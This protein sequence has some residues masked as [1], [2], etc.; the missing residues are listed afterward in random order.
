MSKVYNITSSNFLMGY[1][2][3]TICSAMSRTQNWISRDL[4][5]DVR[6]TKSNSSINFDCRAR[7]LKAV[8]TG[9]SE[10][11]TL[12][13]LSYNNIQTISNESFYKLQ[14]VSTL[15]I[16]WNIYEREKLKNPDKC[17]KGLDV[18]DGTFLSLSN[19][20][21]LQLNADNI[22][23]IPC[24]LPSSLTILSMKS[25]LIDAVTIHN[26]ADLNNL[27]ELF[28]DKN[29]Y[30]D[31][32]CGHA[33]N[34]QNGTFSNLINLVVF[35]FSYNNLTQVPQHL[36]VSLQKLYLNNNRIQNVS[37]YDFQSLV[38][39]T[40]LD[41]S[42][43]CPRCFNAPNPC[44]PCSGDFS[45]NIHPHAFK[46]IKSLQELYLGGN[47]LY[48]IKSSWFSNAENLKVLD[49]KLNHLTHEIETGDFP[50][51]LPGLERLELSFNYEREKYP[52]YMSLSQNFSNLTSLR[53]LIMRGYVFQNVDTSLNPLFLLKNL[54]VLNLEINFIKQVDWHIFDNM[55]SLTIIDL[56]QNNIVPI[57]KGNNTSYN[58]ANTINSQKTGISQDFLFD[59][60]YINEV[61][62]HS[63][64]R[65]IFK[66]KCN[67]YGKVL[68]LSQ[69][70]IFFIAQEQFKHFNDVACL[71]LSGNALRVPLNGTEFIY[72]TNVQYLDMS[73]NEVDL[74]YDYAFVELKKLEILDLSYNAYYFLIIGITHTLAFIEHLPKLKILNLNG[75][76]IATLTNTNLSS[77]SLKV[78]MF[79]KNRLDVLWKESDERHKNLFSNLINLTDLNISRNRLKFISPSIFQN[80]P[81]S[82]KILNLRNNQLHSFDFG[83]L[84]YFPRLRLLDLSS[85]ILRDVTLNLQNSSLHTLLLARNKIHTL[86]DEFLAFAKSLRYLDLSYNKLG[87]INQ[88]TF[89][90]ENYL[91]VL[92]LKGNPF[93]CTCEIGSFIR[94][95]YSNDV[96]IPR[97]ATDVNC[98]SPPNQ[99]G[100]SIINIDLHACEMDAL[101]A[102]IFFTSSF[103]ILLTILIPILKHLFHWDLWY[104]YHFCLAKYK[105]YKLTLSNN[106]SY[107]AFISY[108]TKDTAVTDWVVNEL[109]TQLENKE[110][111]PFF[112]C[113][114]ERD[115]QP[116]IA[117]IDN[118]SYS[119]HHS[120]KSIFI[121]TDA[122]I[123]TVNFKLAFYMAHQRLMDESVDVIVL[124]LLDPVLRLSR[125]LKLK[126]RLC[127]NSV[128]YWPDNPLAEVLFWQR[129][130]NVLSG[131]KFLR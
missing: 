79:S 65:D 64:N 126:R 55:N 80:L 100:N 63:K 96:A 84:A 129:L 62:S 12:L 122:Y 95:I 22:C 85:N 90:T 33:F 49:L 30:Y 107:D 116:G 20:Y 19:L 14:N 54:S 99:H 91:E 114:E 9:I 113:L 68:D 46:N 86:G 76:Q 6:V 38:N 56:S 18:A 82:L 115:W 130:R 31:N 89:S 51:Y 23:K 2:F 3:L 101:A 24:Q 117:I 75:N 119:I 5:C 72:L 28:L 60:K 59:D 110:Q 70:N 92:L 32:P 127:K 34:I 25:N 1:L 94:W 121:L 105:G 98:A 45:A 111:S 73:K 4:P 8:P 88:S 97:L 43:N 57:Q 69:N 42:G 123:K 40:I 26:F 48:I 29:C 44:D 71:N 74:A 104:T 103:I 39:L 67:S 83:H 50:N 108:D 17:K 16:S 47:S 66:R 21:E 118:L 27:K 106:S 11:A 124:I 53:C 102:A 125:Y 7:R 87:T 36:P 35:S 77:Q 52:L 13:D 112:L 109:C 128:L 120:L 78:L 37:Q 15:N 61:A 93:I 41:L 10:N 81:R 131:D 58:L